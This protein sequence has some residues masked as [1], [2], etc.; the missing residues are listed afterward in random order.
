MIERIKEKV[1]KLSDEEFERL[2]RIEGE[3]SIEMKESMPYSSEAYHPIMLS[4][5]IFEELDKLSEMDLMKQLHLQPPQ[6][7]VLGNEK[8]GKSS[9]LER[10]V[11]FPL[12]PKDKVI[13]CIYRMIF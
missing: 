11:G 10:L 4:S 1:R 13:T 7:V 8:H 3:S 12:F 6:I 2:Q 9:M 5:S